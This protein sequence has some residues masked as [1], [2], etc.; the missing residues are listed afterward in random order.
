MSSAW[1]LN[2]KE[3]TKKTFEGKY[4]RVENFLQ[5]S[6]KKN[7]AN[8]D[9]GIFKGINFREKG[10]KFQNSIKLLPISTLPTDF[11]PLWA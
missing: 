1:V 8:I 3:Q 10:Q 11:D 4:S 6:D 9:F 2:R 7:F 5:F